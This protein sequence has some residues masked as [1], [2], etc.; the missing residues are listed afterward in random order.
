MTFAAPGGTASVRL[1]IF[2]GKFGAPGFIRRDLV[3]NG[4]LDPRT[5]INSTDG[6]KTDLQVLAINYKQ[7][8]DEPLKVNA[9]LMR[10][11]LDRYSNRA[12][13]IPIA[14]TL[15]GQALQ[16]D[17]RTTF[18]GSVEKYA[19]WNFRDDAGT[20]VF[21][22]AGIRHDEVASK[23]FNTIK[24]TPGVKSENTDFTLFN[25]FAYAQAD[26]KPNTW[27]KL[28]AGLRYDRLEFDIHDRQRDLD[29]APAIDIVQPKAGVVFSPLRGL[30]LFANYGKSFLPPSATGGQLSRNPT[31]DAPRL[32]TKEIG[33]QYKSADGGW[34]ILAD[35]Y[36]T[37]FTNEILN[38][39]PP[40]L[41]IYLGPSRR[42]GF[43]VEA[44]TRLYREGG[45][46][47]SAFIN[48][49]KVDGELV[50]RATGTRIPDVAEAFLKYGFDLAW[51][52]GGVDS[53]RVIAFSASQVWEGQK[54][55]NT[56]G[57]LETK[58]FSRVDAKLPY[59]DRN[60]KGGSAF[61]TL[62]AYPDRR[63]DETAFTF[64]TPATV[65]VSP[66][67]RLT[68]QGGTFIPFFE[69]V[70]SPRISTRLESK[71]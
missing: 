12:S 50:G 53:P 38:Q 18:G 3:E 51:P 42:D 36:R 14:E 37:T 54:P 46:A 4:T 30:S 21:V 34:Q 22:G 35:V 32:A 9:Y 5:A 63:L 48:Y 43:D 27:I 62:I 10:S 25:P 31:L 28:T 65:G 64:G 23:I 41:P 49:S 40:L 17:D 55:L 24:R 56:T 11:E 68:L 52:R 16:Q 13:T 61:L 15:P 59:T 8:G 19:R 29:V 44:R 67:A 71:S 47:A 45:R 7:T 39:T 70:D 26:Y 2:A 1:Q 6:G 33:V 57:T 69:H 20:A 66:K 60:W 58:T